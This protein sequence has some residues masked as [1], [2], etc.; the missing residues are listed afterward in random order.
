M[1]FTGINPSQSVE[2]LMTAINN[3]KRGTGAVSPKP[4]L[5]AQ[6]KS[7]SAAMKT[8]K[9]PENPA[10]NRFLAQYTRIDKN[11]KT[12]T[13]KNKHLGNLFDSMA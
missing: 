8:E 7:R 3:Y 13:I 2:K 11:V 1:E 9:N 4:V 12:V 10:L 6:V 5:A